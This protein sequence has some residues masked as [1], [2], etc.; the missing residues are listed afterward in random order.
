MNM[1]KMSA[2][3]VG[4]LAAL[5]A[6]AAWN[7]ALGQHHWPIAAF[8]A[9]AQARQAA[10]PTAAADVA[11]TFVAG[12]MYPGY[13]GP[14]VA[15]EDLL[16][17]DD[18]RRPPSVLV[19]QGLDHPYTFRSA[20]HSYALDYSRG[21]TAQL[22]DSG[23]LLISNFDIRQADFQHQG[24]PEWGSIVDVWVRGRGNL[25]Q[26]P[27]QLATFPSDH[28]VV[29]YEE[30]IDLADGLPALRRDLLD[31]D[32]GTVRMTLLAAIRG[33]IIEVRGEG[34]PKA[35][36]AISRTLREYDQFARPGD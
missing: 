9:R 20:Q 11:A 7:V 27:E 25:D 36:E 35:F 29:I 34:D 22:D 10:V 2:V 32:T 28:A 15:P 21:W 33:Q 6:A 13:P 3:A 12:A 18:P 19:F 26:V 14:A 5:M 30:R 23:R 24:M 16:A 4:F 17:Q 1:H 31:Q 8:G